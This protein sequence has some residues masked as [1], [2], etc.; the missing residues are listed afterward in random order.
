MKLF[1]D[2]LKKK[3]I[4]I[5]CLTSPSCLVQL[6]DLITYH[7]FPP[8]LLCS[9]AALSCSRYVGL[10]PPSENSLTLALLP[11]W[12]GLTPVFICHTSYNLGLKWH[13][14]RAFPPAFSFSCFIFLLAF[15]TMLY[16]I[17]YLLLCHRSLPLESQL[18]DNKDLVLSY[19]DNS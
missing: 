3:P 1:S 10:I 2:T 16:Y 14:L 8:S 6:S 12:N 7:C 9:W 4:S 17:V 15:I 18:H 5:V 11:T 13:F 19:T